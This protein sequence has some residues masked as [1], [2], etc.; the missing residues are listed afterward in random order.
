MPGT[1][2]AN[3][4]W[5]DNPDTPLDSS[6]LSKIMDYQS[7]SKFIYFTDE[8]SD[9]EQWADVVLTGDIET[10]DPTS[11]ENLVV[12]SSTTH[13]AKTGHQKENGEYEWIDLISPYLKLLKISANTKISI[14]YINAATQKAK[15]LSFEIDQEDKV[16]SIGQIIT[17]SNDFEANVEYEIYLY[18]HISY[19]DYSEIKIAKKSA[20]PSWKT[21]VVDDNSPSGYKVVALRLIGGFKTNSSKQINATTLWDLSTYRKEIT[22]E[23]YKVFTSSGVRNLRAEDIPIED[24]EGIYASSNVEA[25]LRENKILLNNVR[26]DT[27]TTNRF[28]FE[29]NFSYYK[30]DGS[31]L[32]ECSNNELTLK[33]K[34]GFID[35]FGTRVTFTEDV[36]LATA[37]VSIRVEDNDFDTGITLGDSSLGKVDE[38]IWRVYI[39]QLGK[40]IFKQEPPQYAFSDKIK[41]WYDLAE[42]SRCIGK[43]NVRQSSGLN[44]F[45]EKMSITETMDQLIPTNSIIVYHGTMCPDGLIPCD[46]KWHDV[47]GIDQNAYSA[48]PA[49]VLWQSG[50]WYEET[51]NLLSRTI[52]MPNSTTISIDKFE[53]DGSRNVIQ[54]GSDQTGL[55]GGSELHNHEYNHTHDPGTLRIESVDGEHS[56]Q[57]DNNE[58]LGEAVGLAE[59]QD[60]TGGFYVAARDHIHNMLVGGGTHGHE[61]FSGTVEVLTTAITGNTSTWA[62]YKE[63]LFCIKK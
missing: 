52:K 3:M 9:Y 38:G 37:G 49:T 15:Y 14:Q 22:S 57:I 41:G 53:I 23:S 26:N 29:L 51:P 10:Y 8:V 31:T 25:A 48:M 17:G 63:I 55:E 36:Y 46:G 47:N 58:F 39:N 20:D 12:Y 54:G 40:I 42:G 7:D 16:F 35:I 18:K 6:N 5:E 28:G 19:G 32:I 59:V 2:H 61:T 4:I 24:S 43:F 60:A 62:P 27:Y 56:H 30:K 33:I 34:K 21:G 11:Y 13:E 44:Y 45:I 1:V 50:S